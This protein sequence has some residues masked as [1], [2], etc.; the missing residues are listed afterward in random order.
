M[1]RIELLAVVLIEIILLIIAEKTVWVLL[2]NLISLLYS[3]KSF[4]R[5]LIEIFFVIFN[6]WLHSMRLTLSV[7]QRRL[8]IN[9]WMHMWWL[10]SWLLQILRVGVIH[11]FLDCCQVLF[12]ITECWEIYIR[13]YII[14]WGHSFTHHTCH[15]N[16]SFMS[17]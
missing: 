2:W 1:V 16:R 13:G 9:L 5:L 6:N 14:E 7:L 17:S 3:N 15:S 8:I 10:K 12:K 4:C 11:I